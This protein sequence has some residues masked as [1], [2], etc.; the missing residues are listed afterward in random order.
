MFVCVYAASAVLAVFFQ[1]AVYNVSEGSTVELV[2]V[3]D[4]IFT[5]PVSVELSTSNGSA[6]QGLDF[7]GQ[8]IQVTLDVASQSALVPVQALHDGLCEGAEQFTV[9]LSQLSPTT[10]PRIVIGSPSVASVRIMDLTGKC[11]TPANVCLCS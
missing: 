6:V 5:F 4:R 3:T 2:L 8:E 1:S 9:A 10:T 11:G 7:V